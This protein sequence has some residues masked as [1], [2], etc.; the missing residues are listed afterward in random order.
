M[1]AQEYA[2]KYQLACLRLE[3]ECK[4]LARDV[5][6]ASLRTHF[7]AMA[8]TWRVAAERGPDAEGSPERVTH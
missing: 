7:A 6:S 4:Q 5:A 8:R 3:A 1:S 2:L